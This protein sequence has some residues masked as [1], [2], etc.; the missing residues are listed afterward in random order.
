M[1]LIKQSIADKFDLNVAL[2]NRKTKKK[3]G[4]YTKYSVIIIA[5]SSINIIYL[6]FMDFALFYPFS[7]SFNVSELGRNQTPLV[8]ETFTLF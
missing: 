6:Y 3:L 8:D 7:C 5:S 4:R 1:H 2:R